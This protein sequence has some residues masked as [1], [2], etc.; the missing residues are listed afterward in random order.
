MKQWFMKMMEGRYGVDHFTTFL[1]VLALI[2]LIPTVLIHLLVLRLIL[3]ILAVFVLFYAYF[4]I[5]SRN[6]YARYQEN[7]KYLTFHYSVKNFFAKQK[8]FQKQRKTHRI[9]RCPNCHQSIRVPKGKGRIAIT[10]PKCST[11]FIKKT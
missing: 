7:E 1:M 8:D 10:C 3:S 4:R 9:F 2:L 11:E 5:F 6:H